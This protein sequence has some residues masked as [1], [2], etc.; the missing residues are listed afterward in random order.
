MGNRPH[1]NGGQLRGK[2]NPTYA[3]RFILFAAA[4]MRSRDPLTA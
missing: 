4:F 3:A 1:G 2:A